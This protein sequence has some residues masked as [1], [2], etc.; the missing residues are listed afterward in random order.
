MGARAYDNSLRQERAAGTRGRILDAVRDLLVESRTSLSIPEIAARA[1]VSEPTIYRYF[2]NRD[3][4]L[5]A[6][7]DV[8]AA[9][10]GAPPQPDDASDLPVVAIAVAQYFSENQSWL[11]AALNEPALR[12]LRMAGRQRR[13][14]ALRALLEPRLG[15]LEPREREMAFAMVAIIARADTWDCLTRDFGLSSDE[16]GRAKSWTMQ[17]LLDALAQG[18]RRKRTQLVDA[19][20]IVRGRAWRKTRRAPVK[21]KR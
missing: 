7:S 8:V 15:H 20:T 2:P 1:G 11:R 4:L 19:E 16:A 21:E 9:Q 17:A 12:P 14:A 13:L 5:D 3:A 6:A 18:R 10:L